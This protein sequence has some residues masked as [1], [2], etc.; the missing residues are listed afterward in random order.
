MSE[1]PTLSAITL[2][3][4]GHLDVSRSFWYIRIACGSTAVPLEIEAPT[5][6]TLENLGLPS[7]PAF[8]FKRI[9]TVLPS[10]AVL[11]LLPVGSS[12]SVADSHSSSWNSHANL[13]A[14]S[15]THKED[16]K[17]HYLLKRWDRGA[18]VYIALWCSRI[19]AV[20]KPSEQRLSLTF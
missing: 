20:F 18:S 2:A 17:K 3:F 13:P 8:S 15:N 19:W 10:S 7:P 1:R 11:E 4:L 12:L 9:L 5:L 14:G 16:I 6:N